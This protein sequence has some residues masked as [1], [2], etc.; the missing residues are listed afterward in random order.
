MQRYLVILFCCLG[1]AVPARADSP[2]VPGDINEF[3][4]DQCLDCHD[5]ATKKG[6]LDLETLSRDL[7]QKDAMS[8]WILVHD[9]AAS[10][11]MPPAKRERPARKELDAFLTALRT[12][13]VTADRALKEEQGRTSWRR[14]NRFEYENALRDLLGAPWL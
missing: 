3:L 1:P 7:S 12:P 11:E 6:G 4:I 2:R 9:R 10:G 14:L 8:K 13:L 5:S